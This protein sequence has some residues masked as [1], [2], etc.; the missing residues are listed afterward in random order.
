M[1]TSITFLI[2]FI[3]AM[4]CSCQQETNVPDENKIIDL[5]EKSA[6]LIEADN[7]FGFD[8]FQKIREESTDEN[9]MISPLS[10]SVA[11]AMA[12]NGADGET[13]TEM[14]NAMKLNGLTIE[15][16][17]ASYEMLIDALQSLDKDVVFEIANA[18]Y[19]HQG[20]PVKQSF[21]DINNMY[22]H[23][24]VNSL[25]FG[26]P[27]TIQTINNWV[28]NKTHDKIEKIIDSLSPDARMVLLN[29]IYFYGTW[30]KEF[31]EN[32]TKMLNFRMADSSYKEVAMMSKE[33]KVEYS[34]NPL[35]SAVKLPYGTGQ[36][37]MIVM[38][39]AEGKT[40]QNLIDELNVENWKDW[41][42]DFELT[43]NVIVTMPR[44]KYAFELQ[45]NNVL[46]KMGMLKAFHS[47]EAD[48]SKISDQFLYI[49]SVIHKS[50]I[51]VNETGTEAAAVTAIVFET[52]SVGPGPQK[53]YFTVDKPFVYAITEK[54]TGAIL[55][56]GEV[57][58]PEY[59]E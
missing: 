18:I 50:Y 45:L 38:R 29:A 23:A 31:D 58:N 14:E 56:I 40:S 2:L 8:I 13:K 15:Q 22:Y 49:S 1:K 55:F 20:F 26:N 11:L 25:D 3:L 4:F 12:Y 30:T 52:T 48:F 43:E 7:A 6:Q 16:I 39:P 17:N 21:Y 36:Y 46:K 34:T 24:E 37:N 54:D 44:F 28:A 57:Q 33:D 5:D 47:N 41:D 32:G 27:S 35:F 59:Q 53:I 10:I 51:D 9:L 19:S 42:K